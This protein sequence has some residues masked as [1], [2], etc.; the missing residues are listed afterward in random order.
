MNKATLENWS[1]RLGGDIWTAPEDRPRLIS[2]E[3]YGHPSHADGSR[4]CISP[5]IAIDREART[6]TTR[7]TEY[8]LG[9]I[10]PQYAQFIADAEERFWNSWTKALAGAGGR[11]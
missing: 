5:P 2:G 11:S 4:V 10:D 9:Q 6:V 7:H 8:T 3:V 1:V